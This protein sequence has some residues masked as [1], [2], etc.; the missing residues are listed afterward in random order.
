[1]AL[2][3]RPVW[4][5]LTIFL[6]V[7]GFIVFWPL[8]LAMLGYILWGDRIGKL[9][10][11]TRAQYRGAGVQG[12]IKHSTGNTTF[13]RYRQEEL[14]RLEAERARLEEEAKAF[15]AYMRELRRAKDQEEF[16]R[17]RATRTHQ[18]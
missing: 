13:D 12:V 7:L 8:G 4:S 5:P 18:G 2:R 1:M 10:D 9:A 6:M 11:D 15:E 17:F 3:I 14:A 16:E